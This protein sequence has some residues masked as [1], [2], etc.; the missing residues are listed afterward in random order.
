VK[1]KTQIYFIISAFILLGVLFFGFDIYPSSTKALEKSRALNTQEYDISSYQSEAKAA[2]GEEDLKYLETLEVQAQHAGADSAKIN[3]LKQLS[4]YWFRLQNPIMAGLYAREIASQEE[5]ATSWAITGTTFASGLQ[6]DL[7]EKKK[8][9]LR[10]EAVDA[11]EKAISLEPAVID[12]RV[13]Q[14]LCYIEFPAANEPMKGIQMLVGLTNNYPESPV[15]PYQ[16]ARLA[17]KTGQY[18]RGL[19]RIE[20]ALALDPSN[21]RIACLAIEIYTALN[22]P[23]EAK[24]LEGICA[25]QQ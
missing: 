21:A 9:F 17:V 13:N 18:E 24:A 23:D 19:T 14:A 3:V 12:H 2:L 8:A 1:H 10:D 25:E 15:P 16:L 5:T 4:G 20:Q 22:R 7:D 11:F 6:Q